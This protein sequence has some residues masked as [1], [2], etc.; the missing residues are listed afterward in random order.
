MFEGIKRR[1]RHSWDLLGELICL[2]FLT[3]K[4]IKRDSHRPVPRQPSIDGLRGSGNKALA[5]QWKAAVGSEIL[6]R[7]LDVR[8]R[9]F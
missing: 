9:R 1:N 7:S 6:S 8:Q 5:R 4:G 3:S 2:L